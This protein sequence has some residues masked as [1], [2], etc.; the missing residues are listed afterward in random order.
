MQSHLQKFSNDLT[1]LENLIQVQKEVQEANRLQ[2]WNLPMFE[3]NDIF[4][5]LNH[6]LDDAEK[7]LE[8][9]VSTFHEVQRTK[10]SF[11]VP[12]KGLPNQ[13][14]WEGLSCFL[15][16]KLTKAMMEDHK[17]D[18]ESAVLDLIDIGRAYDREMDGETD[19]YELHDD[20]NRSRNLYKNIY[21]DTESFNADV[22]TMLKCRDDLD[23]KNHDK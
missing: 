4:N 23:V 6:V 7:M 19:P 11:Q 21:D 8:T 22:K 20:E 14:M 12:K 5:N 9:G 15:I 1:R 2:Q 16:D 17:E 18:Y 13:G 3:I 10:L